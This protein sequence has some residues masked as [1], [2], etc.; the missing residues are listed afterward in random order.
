MPRY[1]VE[2]RVVYHITADSRDDAMDK[3]IEG[4]EFPVVPYDDET[5]CTDIEVSTVK[6]LSNG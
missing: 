1:E 5:Y 2:V 3:I 4:A 6:E